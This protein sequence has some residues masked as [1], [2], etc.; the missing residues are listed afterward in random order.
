[1]KRVDRC[2]ID[3]YIPSNMPYDYPYK[4]VKP[5]YASQRIRDS[6]GVLIMDSGIGNDELTNKDVL[7]ISEKYD[8]D[9]VVAKDYLNDQPKTTKSV[10]QFIQE[11]ESHSTRAT[12]VIPLQPNHSE[13]YQDLPNHYH[14]MLGGMA[15]DYN[16]LEVINAIEEFRET[17]GMGPYLHILGV[18][19]NRTFAEWVATNP[20]MVQSIDCSTPEQCAINGRIMDVNFTQRSFQ[21][22]SGKGSSLGRYALAKEMALIMNDA[23]VHRMR[24][25]NAQT[26]LEAY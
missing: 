14:Y 9:M 26:K 7:D 3:I 1:M 12:P 25:P 5:S 6:C 2:P 11:W 18:G 22:M 19:A 17:I 24:E 23:I 8:A 15:F 21:L 4:L 10:R 13:H 20:D 16:P